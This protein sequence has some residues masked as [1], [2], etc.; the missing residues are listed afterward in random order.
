M[1]AKAMAAK[2]MAAK[3]MAGCAWYAAR[4]GSADPP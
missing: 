3:A 2:A 4:A 1:A